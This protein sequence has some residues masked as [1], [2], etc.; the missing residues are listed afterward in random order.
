MRFL[1]IGDDNSLGDLYRRL[2]AEGHEVKVFIGDGRHHG[3]LANLVERI[4]DW[5]AALP[6]LREA[7][8]GGIL[9]FE[10]A[11]DGTL[12]DEL[13]GAGYNVIGG[14]EYG[15]RL[16]NDRSF[17]QQAMRAAGMQIAP[18]SQF[19]SFGTAIDFVHTRPDRY[20]FKLSGGTHSS[21]LNYVGELGDGRDVVALLRQMARQWPSAAGKPDFILMRHVSGVEVGVGAYF[22]GESFMEPLCLDWEHKRFFNG[23]LGELTGEMGTLV[24]Y[25]HARPLFAATLE[26]MA[27]ALRAGAY[28][29]YINLNT[30]VNDDGIWPLE[31]TCRFGYPGYAILSALHIEGWG[32]LFRRMIDRSRTD[33]RTAPGCAV[34]VVLTVPPFPHAAAD[35]ENDP[36]EG[37][38]IFF[39]SALEHDERQHLHFDEVSL[40][41]GNLVTSGGIGYVMVVTGQGSDAEEARARAYRLA[42]KVAIP[43]LRY[44]MDIGSRFIAHDAAIMQRLGLLPGTDLSASAETGDA[45]SAASVSWAAADRGHDPVVHW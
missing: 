26:R 44:R 34:G 38:P 19:D 20:V 41:D 13:R 25:R 27:S 4:D 28:V 1:G 6:W 10:T 36:S 12:Q 40:V 3:A 42:G 45:V 39:R 8:Q 32:D 29:G 7:G 2:M 43:N 5:R 16:E 30:I 18:S 35:A 15:D 24:T 14:S 37:L 31:F 21:S 23:D 11:R 9:L 33:F 22:N 17:G